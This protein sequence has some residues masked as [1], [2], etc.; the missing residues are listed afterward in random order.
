MAG[1]KQ[2]EGESFRVWGEKGGGKRD[3]DVGSVW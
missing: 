2:T 1:L 3:E